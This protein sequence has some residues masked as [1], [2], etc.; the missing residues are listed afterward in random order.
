M[1]RDDVDAT[2]ALAMDH[3]RAGRLTDAEHMYREILQHHPHHPA[4]LHHLG[5]LL[6]RTNRPQLAAEALQAAVAA[7]P[8]AASTHALLAQAFQSLGRHSESIESLRRAI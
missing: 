5:T 1:P 8:S 7:N 2:L 4:T 3:H 6:L